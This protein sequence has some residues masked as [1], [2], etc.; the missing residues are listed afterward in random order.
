MTPNRTA[1]DVFVLTSVGHVS[2][3]EFTAWLEAREEARYQ[4]GME[5]GFNQGVDQ[6]NPDWVNM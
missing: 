2:E 1:H 3:N 6:F 4:D 5:V